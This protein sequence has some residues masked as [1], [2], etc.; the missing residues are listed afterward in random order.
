M[1]VENGRRSGAQRFRDGL[2]I[3]ALTARPLRVRNFAALKMGK[4][5]TCDTKNIH[6]VFNGA[7]ETKKG[8]LIEFDYPR[9]LIAPMRWYLDNARPILRERA[10]LPDDGLMWIGR[11]GRAMVEYEIWQRITKVTKR[12]LGHSINP[13]LFRD[14][15]ATAVAI[16]DP[17]HIG[18][19]TPV[20]GHTHASSKKYYN[21]ATSFHAAQRHQAVIARLRGG[22]DPSASG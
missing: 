18:I 19:V 14:C 4:T 12:H 8:N 10:T 3:A 20:L 6:V 13:H 11:R 2:M 1:P 21:Q 7:G 5:L 16:H 17:K 15:V 22:A 9:A